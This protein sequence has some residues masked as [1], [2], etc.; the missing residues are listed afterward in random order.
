MTD[1]R[2]VEALLAEAAAGNASLE[3]AIAAVVGSEVLVLLTERPA[4]AEGAAPRR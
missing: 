4:E 3:E 2:D 1:T